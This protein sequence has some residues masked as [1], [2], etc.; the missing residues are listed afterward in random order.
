MTVD[1][2]MDWYLD[3]IDADAR[4]SSKTRFDYRVSIDS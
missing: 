4:L 1:E 2:L 3:G